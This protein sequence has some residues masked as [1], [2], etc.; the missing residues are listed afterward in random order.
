MMLPQV[1]VLKRAAVKHQITQQNGLCDVRHGFIV[2]VCAC[3]RGQHDELLDLQ[4]SPICK[5][6]GPYNAGQ[7][8]DHFLSTAPLINFQMTRATPLSKT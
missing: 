4:S 5:L 8:F 6:Y 2:S 7:F 1:Y 3:K